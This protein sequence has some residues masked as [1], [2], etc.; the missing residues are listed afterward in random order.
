[1][2]GGRTGGGA[3]EEAAA[4][5]ADVLDLSR[6]EGCLARGRRSTLLGV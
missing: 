5:S 2:R 4:R 6:Y 3:I 1:L